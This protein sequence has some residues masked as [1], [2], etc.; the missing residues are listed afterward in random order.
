[1]IKNVGHIS[2]K[3]GINHMKKLLQVCQLI[4]I[5][6]RHE[7]DSLITYDTEDGQSEIFDLFPNDLFNKWRRIFKPYEGRCPSFG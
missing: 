6:M 3:E 4:S 5:N 2:S 7:V 1:M